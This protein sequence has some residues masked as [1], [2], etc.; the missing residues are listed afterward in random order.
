MIRISAQYKKC[1]IQNLIIK[2]GKCDVAC[3]LDHI[4]KLGL[5]GTYLLVINIHERDK[6]KKDEEYI[7]MK[8][9]A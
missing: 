9:T 1:K 7:F 4:D 2:E 5:L 8:C 6:E 3:V